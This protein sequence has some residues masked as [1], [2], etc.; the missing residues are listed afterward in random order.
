MKVTPTKLR[1][2]I[3]R[4]LDQVLETG[5]PI[6]IERNGRILRL[7]PDQPVSKLGNLVQRDCIIGD[8]EELVHMD[9]SSEWNP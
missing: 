9:W 5:I 7:V 4:L 1:R 3:Y 2:D 6:E 8:P